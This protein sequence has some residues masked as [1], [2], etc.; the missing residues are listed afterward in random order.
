MKKTQIGIQLYSVREALAEDFKGT[1]SQLSKL[2]FKGVEFA[3]NYGGL[4]PDELAEFLQEQNLQAIGIYEQ[5]ANLC[6]PDAEVYAHAS[7]LGCKHLTFGTGLADLEEDFDGFLDI[8][9]K[10]I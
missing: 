2:G 4:T 3:F 10:I 8:C 7:A 5:I 6:N 1:L 9:R